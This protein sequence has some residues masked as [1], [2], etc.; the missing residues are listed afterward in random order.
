[1]QINIS[2]LKNTQEGMVEDEIEMQTTVRKLKVINV[3]IH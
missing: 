2:I 1:M 3:M